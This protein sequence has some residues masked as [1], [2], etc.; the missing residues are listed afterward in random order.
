MLTLPYS[1]IL[2]QIQKDLAVAIKVNARPLTITEWRELLEKEGFQVKNVSSNEMHL[3]EPSRM[4]KDEGFFRTLKI[5]FNILT[6]G[7][8]RKRILEMRKTFHKHQH[9]MNAV[10]IV[11]EKVN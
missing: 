7:A 1:P 9:H 10:A 4:V 8:A 11:A 3:L 5:G 6:H 2:E